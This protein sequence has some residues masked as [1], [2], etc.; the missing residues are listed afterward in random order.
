MANTIVISCPECDKQMKVPEDLA[1]KKIRCKE[2]DA[3]FTVKKPKGEPAKSKPPAKPKKKEDE[4]PAKAATQDDEDD[5]GKNPYALS[6]DADGGARCPHCIKPMDPDD[7][8]CLNC[9]FNIVTRTRAERKAVYEPTGQEKF[10]WLLP[11]IC[12]VLGIMT[13]ITA[14][15]LIWLKTRGWMEGGWFQNDDKTY[16]IKPGCFYL[17]NVMITAFFCWHLGKFAFKRLV[18]NYRPPEK[19]IEK[20]KDDE[21]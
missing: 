12:A 20:E 5:D 3:T 1:G 11:G 15:V 9:G 4:K 10:V 8:V 17:M 7:K 6:G 2:C 18:K 19:E 16:L 13:M 21:D 14:C